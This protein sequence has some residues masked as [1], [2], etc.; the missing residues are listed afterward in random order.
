MERLEISNS[1]FS[2]NFTEKSEILTDVDL[3]NL[4]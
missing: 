3:F 4:F 1:Y 2:G